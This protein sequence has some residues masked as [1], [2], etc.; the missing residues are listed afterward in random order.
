MSRRTSGVKKEATKPQAPHSRQRL[1]LACV[2]LLVTVAVYAQVYTHGFVNYDD[3]DYVTENAHVQAG[4]S[5]KSV[6]W[7]FTSSSAANWIPLTWLSHMLDCQIFGLRSGSHHL[8]NLLFHVLSA[9]L[10][11]S[12]LQR[13]TAALWPSLAVAFLFALHPLH[14]ESVCWISERKDVLSGFFWFLTI[15]LYLR[16]VDKPKIVR[17]SLVVAAYAAGLMAKQMVVTLPLVLLLLDVWPLRR[18][19][20]AGESRSRIGT[21]V[22]EKIPLLALAIGGSVI[23]YVVQQRGGAVLPLE[24]IPLGARIANAIDS[25]IVYIVQTFC[26]VRLAVFYPFRAAPHFGLVAAA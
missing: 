1:I 12:V 2:L 25:Y 15:W 18:I 23:A 16:Y 4:L 10:L 6:A 11:F 14:A 13:L 19:G 17:Y 7:A 8:S 9:L 21:T 24:A 5:A 3:P 20:V 26:P 22:L